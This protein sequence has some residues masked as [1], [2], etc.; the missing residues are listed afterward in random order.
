MD[1]TKQCSNA[2]KACL[3]LFAS[4]AQQSPLSLIKAKGKDVFSIL[5]N[6]IQTLQQSTQI[7]LSTPQPH[8]QR[9]N[10]IQILLRHYQ[11][12]VQCMNYVAIASDVEYPQAGLSEHPKERMV[13]LIQVMADTT[14]MM[15][16][17]Y[18][19]G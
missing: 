13:Q 5:Q 2:N 6:A 17:G 9:Q 4:L 11:I 18:S 7:I 12:I 15:T 10:Q 1:N 8:H 3:Q 16:N 14:M 19:G